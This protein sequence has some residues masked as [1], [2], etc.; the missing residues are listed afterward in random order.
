MAVPLEDLRKLFA[1]FSDNLRE[2]VKA[3][4]KP[5]DERLLSLER[6]RSRPSSPNTQSDVEPARKVETAPRVNEKRGSYEDINSSIY[7]ADENDEEAQFTPLRNNRRMSSAVEDANEIQGIYRQGSEKNHLASSS[8]S[9][10]Y[11]AK[12]PNFSDIK[13]ERADIASMDTFSEKLRN[14]Q[15]MYGVELK[16]PPLVSANVR[17]LLIANALDHGWRTSETQFYRYDFA[18]ITAMMQLYVRPTDKLDFYKKMEK[19]LK[20]PSLYADYKLS[21]VNFLPMFQA[22]N[23]FKE[24]Y[25]RIYDFLSHDNEQMVPAINNKPGGLLLILINKIPFDY[26]KGVLQTIGRFQFTTVHEMWS[27]VFKQVNDDKKIGKLCRILQVRFNEIKPTKEADSN[28]SR[29]R[30]PL[31]NRLHEIRDGTEENESVDVVDEEVFGEVDQLATPAE[32]H[33]LD[34]LQVMAPP[35]NVSGNK[36]LPCL[37]MLLGNNCDAGSKC[38]F[39]HDENVL[40]RAWSDQMKRLQASKYKGVTPGITNHKVSHLSGQLL[41]SALYAIVPHAVVLKAVYKEGIVHVGNNK[42]PVQKVLFDSGALTGSYIDKA[43]VDKYHDVFKDARRMPLSNRT[44]KLADNATEVTLTEV[45]ELKMTFHHKGEEYSITDRFYVL[46]MRSGNDCIIGLPTIVRKL[47]LLFQSMLEDAANAQLNW[48]GDADTVRLWPEE[49]AEAPEDRDTPMPSSFGNVLNHLA[50]DREEAIK[51]YHS[52]SD[53]QVAPSFAKET[54]VLELLRRPDIVEIF[55][56]SEWRGINGI[57]PLELNIR[58]GRK[59]VIAKPR[60]VNPKIYENAYQEFLRLKKYMLRPSKSVYASPVVIAPK[61]TPPYIRLCGDFQEAN[62]FLYTGYQHIPHVKHRLQKIIRYAMFLDLDMSNSFHQILL[63]QLTSAY[64]SMSTPWGQY[65]PVYMP[66]GISPAIGILQKIVEEIFSDYEE[67]MIVIFDN[68]LVLCNSYEDAYNKLELVLNR[69]KERNIVLKFSK[70]F[71]GFDTANFFG[72]LCRHNRYEITPERKDRIMELPFPKDLKGMQRFIG[73]TLFCSRFIKDYV[74]YASPLHEMTKKTFSWDKSSWTVDYSIPFEELKKQVF[75][76]IALYYP[77][78]TLQWKVFLDASDDG[79]GAVLIQ[80]R[81]QE[82][83]D[84]LPEVIDMAHNKFSEVA[85][86]WPASKKEAYAAPFALKKFEFYLRPKDFILVTDHAN[87]RFMELSTDPLVIRW[88][89]YIKTFK[90]WFEAVR[91]IVNFFADYLSRLYGIVESDDMIGAILMHLPVSEDHESNHELHAFGLNTTPGQSPSFYL[92]QVHGGRMGH[93]GARRTWILLNKY[94][95]GHKIPYALVADFVSTC[96]RCQQ[97]RFGMTDEIQ[98]LTRHLKVDHARSRLGIDTLTVTPVDVYGNGLIHVIV[99][100]WTHH[101]GLYPAKEYS[102][103]TVAT[104]LFQ[105]I[106]LFGRTDELMCDPASNFTAEVMQHLTNWLGVRQLFSLVD[107]HE[108]NGVEGPNKLILRH[109]SALVA[110]E[111]IRNK[112]SDNTVLPIIGY[113]LNDWISSETGASPF[114][115]T[116]GD[117][118]SIYGKLP[119]TASPSNHMNDFIR[120]LE[121]NLATLHDASKRFQENLIIRRTAANPP[122]PN[123][124]QPGDFVMFD[125]FQGGMKDSKL[126][127]PFGGPYEVISHRS[128]NVEGRHVAAGFIKTLHV[129][130]LKLFHGDKDAA[131][132]TALIDINQHVV[133]AFLAYRGEPMSRTSMQFLVEFEDGEKLWLPWSQDLF[134]TVPYETFCRSRSCLYIL[135]FSLKEATSFI[136]KK[137]SEHITAI[138]PGDKVYVDLRCYGSSWYDQLFLPEGDFKSYMLVYEYLNWTNSKH[139]KVSAFCSIFNESFVV[140]GYFVHAYGS[141]KEFDP[142]FM[143]IV[144]EVLVSQFPA[145][146]PNKKN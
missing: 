81:E 100:Q 103:L 97:F 61:S 114:A 85:K 16:V 60:P 1:D 83:G 95:A 73:M 80:Y 33:D 24:D 117:Q 35:G 91:G 128:N 56:P 139:T 32:E 40:K 2:E 36:D 78:Y 110:D 46:D 134:Q 39:S 29:E 57:E 31:G 99:N 12:L 96:S 146:L 10:S 105:H 87:L 4:L 69:C 121:D 43:I 115:L 75:K 55:V 136:R 8:G 19:N 116:F 127:A 143:V 34:A 131:Y 20:F 47:L 59:H 137:N 76:S 108:S 51:K 6:S 18:T 3:M 13:L 66:E 92:S 123:Q 63:G 119:V 106:C 133:K 45:I 48:I 126:S 53:T 65:E 62:K 125:K 120:S 15:S 122:V 64:L 22:V 107:R 74:K 144:D 68:F 142:T 86:R 113:I 71:L 44:V 132:Q 14:Y 140:D 11:H 104:A 25:I 54:K 145:L 21:A 58:E 109:L 118:A 124:Y 30:Q 135:L 88:L 101:C 52:L 84:M 77:D 141:L 27:E 112:W 90:C 93:H 23:Q 50:V 7:V 94:F 9:I 138:Q 17:R 26:M 129:S 98:P 49:V 102:A 89:M 38:K 70:S 111:R 28:I 41:E 72:Y 130:R 79:V 37:R 82:N 5:L 42:I 67:W